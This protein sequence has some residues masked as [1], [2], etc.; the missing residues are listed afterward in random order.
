MFFGVAVEHC[1]LSFP[2]MDSSQEFTASDYLSYQFYSI[3]IIIILLLSD[4][5]FFV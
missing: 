2:G 3:W 4:Y 5:I 1:N